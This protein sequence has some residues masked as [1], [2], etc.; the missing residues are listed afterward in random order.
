MQ[1]TKPLFYKGFIARSLDEFKRL[2][3]IAFTLEGIKGAK[4]HYELHNFQ[5][6]TAIQDCKIMSDVGIGGFS[7]AN[8][9]WV[10]SPPPSSPEK[11]PSPNSPGY[12]RFHGTIST[13]LPKDRPEVKRTGYAAF[14]TRDRPPTIFGRSL[15]NIDPYVYLALRVKSDGRSYFIN[16]QT[17]S[18]IPTDLHQHRLFVKKPGEWETVFVKWNDFVRTNHGFVVEPQ[19]EI[20]RQKVRSIGIGLTD[21]IPGPFE[22]C[23]ERMWATNDERDADNIVDLMSSKA[24][25]LDAPPK[26]GMLKTKQG[27]NVGWED[28]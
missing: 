8:L 15:F 11:P 18:V 1:A 17:E 25:G 23:I 27:Q 9:D 14:R 19:T 22:L 10:T 13:K 3:H 28:K 4:G 6:P 24:A 16:V 7:N 26:E 20:M 12:A 2:S 21:R 5:S